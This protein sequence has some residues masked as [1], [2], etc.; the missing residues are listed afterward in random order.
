MDPGYLEQVYGFKRRWVSEYVTELKLALA[1]MNIYHIEI[2]TKEYL[3]LFKKCVIY[4]KF[5]K[6]LYV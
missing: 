5:V 6:N 3:S 2:F 1:D 4:L